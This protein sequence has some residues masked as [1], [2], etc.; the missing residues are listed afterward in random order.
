MKTTK[1]TKKNIKRISKVVEMDLQ[2]ALS[3]F[4][5]SDGNKFAYETKREIGECYAVIYITPTRKKNAYITTAPLLSV[6]ELCQSSK[7][8]HSMFYGIEI[9]N[10]YDKDSK[11][12]IPLPCISVHI[13]IE[14]DDEQQG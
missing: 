6:N 10:S 1:V 12:C 8:K 7:W 11:S 9:R 14:P 2:K 4:T 5:G 13:K 3:I